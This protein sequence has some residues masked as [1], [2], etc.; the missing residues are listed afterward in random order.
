MEIARSVVARKC[1]EDASPFVLRRVK[2]MIDATLRRRKGHA[3]RVVYGRRHVRWRMAA[4]LCMAAPL[5]Q[6]AHHLGGQGRPDLFAHELGRKLDQHTG[7]GHAA[8]GA[9]GQLGRYI[10]QGIAHARGKL[11]PHGA[12]PIRRFRHSR[13]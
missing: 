4:Q 5:R 9:L 12:H 6:I 2:G 7:L 8:N 3:E 10:V 13:L 11:P 1:L